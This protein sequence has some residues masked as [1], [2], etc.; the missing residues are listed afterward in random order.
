MTSKISIFLSQCD[1][2]N[3]M[4]PVCCSRK[5]I[6]KQNKHSWQCFPFLLHFDDSSRDE[7]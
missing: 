3:C 7:H 6:C 1:Y 5:A 4:W 2:Y